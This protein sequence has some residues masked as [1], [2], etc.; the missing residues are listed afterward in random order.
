MSDEFDLI[1]AY[2]RAQAI[3]DGVLVD[4]SATAAEAGVK[5]PTAVTRAVYERCVRVPEGVEAQDE[6][7]RAWD[8]VWMLRLAATRSPDAD[9][10]HFTVLV[11][12]DNVAPQPVRLKAMCGP[13]DDAEPVVTILLPDED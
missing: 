5:Y 7:G 12:N 3:A 9:R 4:V 13:G 6:A 10:L 1:H 2:T 8:L 11:R